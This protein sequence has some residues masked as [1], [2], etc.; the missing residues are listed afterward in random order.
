MD[1]L[2]FIK[3]GGSL[4]T[5]KSRPFTEKKSVIRRLAKEIHEARKESGVRIILG[6]VRVP[7]AVDESGSGSL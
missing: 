7:Q 5:D 6:H 4:I 3:L 1:D 2:V